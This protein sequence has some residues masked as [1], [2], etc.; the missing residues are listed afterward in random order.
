MTTDQTDPKPTSGS[1]KN[2]S[3]LEE[4]KSLR[5]EILHRQASE[6]RLVLATIAG[7]AAIYAFALKTPCLM[8][9]LVCEVPVV[10]VT[11]MYLWLKR[12][13]RSC[14]RI[15]EYL[16]HNENTIG[17][18]WE[19]WVQKNRDTLKLFDVNVYEVIF[20]TLSLLSPIVA[21]LAVAS[22]SPVTL[23]EGAIA[24]ISIAVVNG[25]SIWAYCRYIKALKDLIAGATT[26][27]GDGSKPM[28]TTT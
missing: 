12:S 17:L 26:A 9:P 19:I 15:A 28:R 2:G 14:H 20:W 25:L 1:G 13:N 8:T 27:P 21:I 6:E 24:V 7:S 3:L 16:R 5:A 22:D 18:G 10:L 11:I 23:R 4:W